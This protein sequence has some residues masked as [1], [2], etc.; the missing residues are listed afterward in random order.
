M[1]PE[2]DP[3]DLVNQ[4]LGA[5]EA[6]TLKTA[7]DSKNGSDNFEGFPYKESSLHTDSQ[8]RNRDRKFANIKCVLC[9]NGHCSDKCSLITDPKAAKKFLKEK[10]FCFLCLTSSHVSSNCSKKKTC[11]YC[12][13][14][15][16]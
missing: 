13:G 6:C 11:Y 14:M 7:E 4:E 16:N 3:R 8:Y 10:D 9:G 15:H 12:K 1:G 5:C 2:K